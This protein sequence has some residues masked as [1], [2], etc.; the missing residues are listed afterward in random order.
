M[1]SQFHNF[2][3]EYLLSYVYVQVDIRKRYVYFQDNNENVKMR[4]FI[5]KIEQ[6]SDKEVQ[7][8]PARKLS[9]AVLE[10]ERADLVVRSFF[11]K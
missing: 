10:K 3:V 4:G 9:D 2:E 7:V 11:L 5:P 8:T 6:K 1:T